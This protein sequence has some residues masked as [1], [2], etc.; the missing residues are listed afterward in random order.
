MSF[1]VLLWKSYRGTSFMVT[2]IQGKGTCL[3]SQW[4]K[5]QHHSARRPLEMRDT[6]VTIS[7]IYNL[8]HLST[9]YLQKAIDKQLEG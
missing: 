7:G 5:S 4:A 2:Q 1:M 3:T 9:L 6:F 8:S